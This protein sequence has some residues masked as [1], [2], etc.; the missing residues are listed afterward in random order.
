M[1]ET[2]QKVVFTVNNDKTSSQSNVMV[3]DKGNAQLSDFGL[4]SVEPI[5]V[6]I[7]GS[8]SIS[9]GNPRWLAPELMFPDLFDGNGR[10]ARE[11]DVYAFGM[12]ALEVIA[13]NL[14]IN[15]NNLDIF[16]TA[17]YRESSFPRRAWDC[18]LRGLSQRS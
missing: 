13:P 15:L 11:S 9:G 12:T 6:T 1:Y 16:P 2:Q 18:V 7:A 14:N 8:M 4:A 17:L 5:H 3:D 10:S